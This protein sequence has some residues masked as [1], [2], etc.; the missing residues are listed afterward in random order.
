MI[1]GSDGSGFHKH[2]NKADKLY[3]FDPG[4]CKPAE[5]VFKEKRTIKDVSSYRFVLSKKV[6]SSIENRPENECYCTRPKRAR[7]ICSKEGVFDL[8]ACAGGAPL[9]LS[10]PHFLNADL[11]LIQKIEDGLSSNQKLH[12]TYI[13]IEPITGSVISAA[14]RIQFNIEVFRNKSLE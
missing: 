12:Q 3:L 6:F 1:K 4:L 10:N 2:V 11:D 7:A 13:D 5:L 8:T 14:K 9:V